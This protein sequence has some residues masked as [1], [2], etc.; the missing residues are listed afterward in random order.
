ML[1]LTHGNAQTKD[2]MALVK[3][4]LANEQKAFTQFIEKRKMD[5]GIKNY[6]LQFANEKADSIV[7]AVQLLDT[8]SSYNKQR[9]VASIDLLLKN[10][11][12]KLYQN[13]FEQFDIPDALQA[14]TNVLFALLKREPFFIYFKNLGPRRSKLV[15]D[16]FA[17]FN[18]GRQMQ[19][20]STFKQL[21]TK[22]EKILPYLNSN[23]NYP[24]FDTLLYTVASHH[25][26]YV[27]SYI[28]NATTPLKHKIE[29]S[30]IPIV[31]Q[32]IKLK[33]NY[34]KQE[35]M[36]FAA[37]LARN[38]KTVEEITTTRKDIVAYYQ[39]LVNT[40]Q[41][42]YRKKKQGIAAPMRTAVEN[43]LTNK[44]IQFFVNDINEKH[45]LT[46]KQRFQS[47]EG[48]RT[49]DLY[50]IIVH[51]EMDLFTSSYLG[52]FKRLM[53][54]YNTQNAHELFTLVDYQYFRRF[55]RIAGHYNT[56]NT[57]LQAMPTE[58]QLALLNK[59][60]SN[61]DA[62][63]DDGVEEAMN[64]ADAFIGLHS[65]PVLDAQVQA[66]IQQN[67]DK[68]SSQK[69]YFGTKLYSILQNVY[70]TLLQQDS[71]SQQIGGY[72]EL[73][74]KDL[75]NTK[76]TVYQQVFFYGD[77]DGLMSFKTYLAI[78][79]KKDWVIDTAASSYWIIIKSVAAKQPTIIYAN[80][81]LHHETEKDLEAIK[82]LQTYLQQQH[83]KPSILIHRGH[84]YH[85]PNT[86][87]YLQPYFKLCI[88]G[89]CGGYKNIITVGEVCKLAHIIA[90]KQT[91]TA[92]VNNPMLQIINNNITNATNI[93]WK[94][95][96]SSLQT[97]VKA[98]AYATSLLAEYVPPYK[99]LGLFVLKLY[100]YD[101]L[102][103]Q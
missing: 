71:S 61:V 15:T 47:I 77:K 48:L 86:L 43:A 9:A 63:T 85:L 22:E 42:N 74:I 78:F 3:I 84:S 26:A 27:V 65:N 97:T 11:R 53:A 80:K 49:Q 69:Q 50:A 62:D 8:V 41:E 101:S 24:Y 76:D 59:F 67:I 2:T 55:M 13:S 37:L 79:N 89:S 44:T 34:N 39:L 93:K 52:L 38:E 32:L 4:S 81:P 31:Q 98:N 92:A 18:R 54:K 14:Y 60:I 30:Q 103:E 64:V 100:N 17:N 91:G 75:L 19:A 1:L 10:L 46:D 23:I 73:S 82:K 88:L 21:I 56:L 68:C 36:P 40:A 83:I 58:Q 90:T 95:V 57:F 99:N 7:K 5:E 20:I 6:L 51:G 87:Q 70:S 102:P 66:I 28:E 12:G 45:E 96:W 25:P 94:E 72:Q 29:K 33:G 16:A 35:I